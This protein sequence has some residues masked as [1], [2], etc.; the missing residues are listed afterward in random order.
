MCHDT[1]TDPEIQYKSKHINI[2]ARLSHLPAWPTKPW[3]LAMPVH[4]ID[5]D[6]IER[7]QPH[8][9]CKHC[10]YDFKGL[11]VEGEC[12]ECGAEYG[13]YCRHC[14]YPLVGRPLA[15]DCPECGC[16]FDK[17]NERKIH[18]R[19]GMRNGREIKQIDWISFLIAAV[20][21]PATICVG[22]PILIDW[23]RDH[24]RTPSI[25]W[26][27]SALGLA[28]GAMAYSACIVGISV[29]LYAT[30]R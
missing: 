7:N 19:S 16:R 9:S 26:N 11:S 21:I 25:R 24:L 22:G 14:R 8:R 17:S 18:W 6:R 20:V 27:P 2:S 29:G 12:P 1:R 13:F 15:G 4:L 10:D 28:M 30:R 23:M 3:R 5:W